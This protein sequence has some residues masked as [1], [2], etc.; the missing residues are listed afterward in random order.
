[1]ERIGQVRHEMIH[2]RISKAIHKVIDSCFCHMSVLAFVGA[3]SL[4]PVEEVSVPLQEHLVWTE[5]IETRAKEFIDTL[6][7]GRFVGIHLRNGVDW[8]WNLEW[9]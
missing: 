5:S 7:R 8:V 6:P 4:F 1:M 9:N 2:P 3:P